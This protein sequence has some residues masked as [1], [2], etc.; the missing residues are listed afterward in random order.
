MGN[1]LISEHINLSYFF[2][3]RLSA[4]RI[5]VKTTDIIYKMPKLEWK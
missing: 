2:H 3:L 4:L 5:T 1:N